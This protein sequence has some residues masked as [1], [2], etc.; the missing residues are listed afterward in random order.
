[1]A[2]SNSSTDLRCAVQT[3]ALGEAVAGTAN[4]ADRWV[5]VET[6]NPWPKPALAHPIFDGLV[7]PSILANATTRTL[8]IGGPNQGQPGY[9][10]TLADGDAVRVLVYER[11]PDAGF[12]GFAGREQLVR[13]ASLATVLTSIH[14]GRFDGDAINSTDVLICTQGSHDRC[15][16]SFGMRLFAEASEALGPDVRVWRTSHT[17]GH[18]FAPTG[19]TFPDGMA[20]AGLDLDLL[21]AIT[22]RSRGATTADGRLVADFARGNSAMS[23]KSAQVA[24][25]AAFRRHGWDWFDAERTWRIDSENSSI[26]DLV[27]EL[28][29]G[30]VHYRARTEPGRTMAVPPCGALMIESKKQS[31]ETALVEFATVS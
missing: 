30:N 31:T 29:D 15:C 11:D 28:A 3:A 26:V 24:D 19:I 16:G 8:L 10:S 14:Q 13:A 1:M 2:S 20:W 25:I 7:D 12:A 18:R 21:S 4:G 22:Q 5:L 27:A 23:S 6:P 17:G 9:T